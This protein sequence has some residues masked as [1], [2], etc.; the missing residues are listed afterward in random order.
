MPETVPVTST[1]R[2]ELPAL[3]VQAERLIELGVHQL[4]GL[5]EAELRSF[6]EAGAAGP[7]ESSGADGS[8]LLAVHPGA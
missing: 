2:P 6:A 3:P 8:T 5:T 4:A 1:V 7:G